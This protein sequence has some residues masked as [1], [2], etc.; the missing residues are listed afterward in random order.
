MLYS[1]Y[2]LVKVLAIQERA[3]SPKPNTTSFAPSPVS[4]AR[5]MTQQVGV[6][7]NAQMTSLHDTSTFSRPVNGGDVDEH[8]ADTVQHHG[9]LPEV[10]FSPQ[11]ARYIVHVLHSFTV[12]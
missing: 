4:S 7:P 9:P 3:A 5:E 11:P 2:Y 10:T 12:E 6:G 1:Y 8:P